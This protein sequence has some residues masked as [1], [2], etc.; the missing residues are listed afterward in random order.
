M[1]APAP[2][3]YFFSAPTATLS[4]SSL[5]PVSPTSFLYLSMLR[6]SLIDQTRFPFLQTR[7]PATKL[8]NYKFR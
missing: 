8:K 5:L 2:P 1:G 4:R 3:G 7:T 6:D